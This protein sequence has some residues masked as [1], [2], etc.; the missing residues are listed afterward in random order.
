MGDAAEICRI[1][2]GL[3]VSILRG[4]GE[5]S[6]VDNQSRV[7]IFVMVARETLG[8][9]QLLNLSILHFQSKIL[10]VNEPNTQ[11]ASRQVHL[12]DRFLRLSHT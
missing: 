5:L 3:R 1:G 2:R 11:E 9:G 4:G 10:T 7:H 6:I 8:E 12:M